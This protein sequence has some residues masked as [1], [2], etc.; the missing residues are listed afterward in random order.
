MGRENLNI[1]F[2]FCHAHGRRY[3]AEA[4]KEIPKEQ[5]DKA[6]GMVAHEALETDG[7]NPSH[8]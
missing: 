1:T 3:F 4:L 6:K 2:A 7:R 5:R 8:G